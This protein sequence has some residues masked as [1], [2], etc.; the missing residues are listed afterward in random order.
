MIPPHADTARHG[1]GDFEFI[2]RQAVVKTGSLGGSVLIGEFAVINED[3]VIGDN[4]VI[5]P[6]VVIEQGVVIDADVEVFPVAYLALM[7]EKGRAA[8]G[9]KPAA[10][11]RLKA[12]G[13]HGETASLMRSR[14]G[15][16]SLQYGRQCWFRP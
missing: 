15:G 16:R 9:K 6:H 4:V 7:S 10:R 1:G 14:A 3:L 8:L 5:H 13:V 2:S 12:S 11:K